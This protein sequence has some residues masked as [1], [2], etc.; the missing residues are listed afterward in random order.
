V[1]IFG[2]GVIKGKVIGLEKVVL[3]RMEEGIVV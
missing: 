2:K 1:G 3:E